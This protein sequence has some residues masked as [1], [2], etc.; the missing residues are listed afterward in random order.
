MRYTYKS[1]CGD[2]G[3]NVGF[4]EHRFEIQNALG[5][6]EDREDPQK[7]ISGEAGYSC[8]KCHKEITDADE[9]YANFGAN[10]CP[11]C[12]QRLDWKGEE[13]K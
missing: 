9:N 4:E 7:V 10:Y 2:Y 1:C 6:L 3:M 11:H 8:P 5:K 12:G 13:K